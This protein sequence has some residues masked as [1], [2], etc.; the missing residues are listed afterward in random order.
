MDLHDAVG[1][2]LPDED[3]V[4]G[5][6][7]QRFP[8]Q[9]WVHEAMAR[10][11]RELAVHGSGSSERRLRRRRGQARLLLVLMALAVGTI[12]PS[13]A[14][15]KRY[16]MEWHGCHGVAPAETGCRFRTRLRGSFGRNGPAFPRVSTTCNTQDD[17]PLRRAPEYH[18]RGWM[19]VDI[20]GDARGR[21]RTVIQ[22]GE[23]G[24]DWRIFN[25]WSWSKWEYLTVTVTLKGMADGLPPLGPW[26][27]RVGI[28]IHE[29]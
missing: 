10:N 7:C 6:R 3:P 18:F 13:E 8:C 5:G 20:R 22:C 28:F 9:D 4:D 12:A 25:D 26:G 23:L 17:D 24:Q 16:R 19:I 14:A 11:M 29:R 15:R 21:D 2:E 1:G 27:A